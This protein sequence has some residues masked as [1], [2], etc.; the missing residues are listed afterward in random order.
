MLL[1]SGRSYRVFMLTWVKFVLPVLIKET[2]K[3]QRAKILA[4][5]PLTPERNVICKESPS[6]SVA[7][8][9]I[10]TPGLTVVPTTALCAMGG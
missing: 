5:I 1:P 8:M 10:S 2:N 7:V 4:I 6:G 3:V 9:G